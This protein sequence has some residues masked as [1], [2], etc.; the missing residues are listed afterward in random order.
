M[1]ITLLKRDT[2]C[3]KKSASNVEEPVDVH[4]LFGDLAVYSSMVCKSYPPLRSITG[5][6]P[7]Q[8]ILEK[9][10][11]TRWSLCSY[12]STDNDARRICYTC[13]VPFFFRTGSG[14][15]ENTD[16]SKGLE[17]VATFCTLSP[18]CSPCMEYVLRPLILE[19][20]PSLALEQRSSS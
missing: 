6:C 1:T 2:L 16:S 9:N 15:L 5:Q 20:I 13:L 10:C 12:V 17:H 7:S 8:Q 19:D 3:R 4:T 18:K 11:R 14:L